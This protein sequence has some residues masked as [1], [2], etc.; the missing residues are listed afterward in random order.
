M[1][2]LAGGVPSLAIMWSLRRRLKSRRPFG[3]EK[4]WNSFASILIFASWSIPPLVSPARCL[5]WMLGRR[6]SPRERLKMDVGLIVTPET[7]K[8]WNLWGLTVSSSPPGSLP[9]CHL[10]FASPGGLGR[11]GLPGEWLKLDVKTARREEQ[12]TGVTEIF[13][14]MDYQS[15][16]LACTPLEDP[17]LAIYPYFSPS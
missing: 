17:V 5:T 10:S 15:H 12:N 14:H 4:R 3:G 9:P 13:E 2:W 1:A 16:L 7:E 6:E 11:P 8:R